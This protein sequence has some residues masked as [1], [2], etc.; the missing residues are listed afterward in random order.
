MEHYPD[1][2]NNWKLF[3]G[4]LSLNFIEEIGNDVDF[5]FIDTVHSNPGEI[6][7][8]LMILPFLKEGAIIVFHDVNYHTLSDK[9]AKYNATGG[10]TN[11]LLFSAIHGKKYIQGNFVER[12]PYS[13]TEKGAYFPNIG[14]IRTNSE[15]K[16]HIF[17]IFNLL[18]LNWTYLP[19]LDEEKSIIDFF[20]KYYDVYFIEYLNKVFAYH[21]KCFEHSDFSVPATGYFIRQIIKKLLGKRMTA[22]IR[23]IKTRRASVRGV[24]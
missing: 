13:N 14:A 15:T 20:S 12:S 5:C 6:L 10:F 17:E 21:R 16:K 9:F 11:N 1:L 22:K 18:T 24:A 2:Q 8:V 19:S 23:E 4:K 3:T 7:D